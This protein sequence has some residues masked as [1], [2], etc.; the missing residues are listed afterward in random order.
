MTVSV[1]AGGQVLETRVFRVVQASFGGDF[2]GLAGSTY[3]MLQATPEDACGTLTNSLLSGTVVLARRGGWPAPAAAPGP[4]ATCLLAAAAL[5]P[6][7]CPRPR[8]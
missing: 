3:T 5:R 8:A 7:W 2:G 1:S 6:A 4:A